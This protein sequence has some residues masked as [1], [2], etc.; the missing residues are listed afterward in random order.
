[1]LKETVRELNNYKVATK[2]KQAA[3]LVSN[4]YAI[5]RLQ[6]VEELQEYIDVSIYG[7][8]GDRRSCPRKRGSP[9][10][11]TLL[12]RHKFYL[13]FENGNCPEYI[14]E[15]YWENAIDNNIVPVVMGGADYKSLAIPNSYID[16][17]DFA[18]PK[19]LAEYLLYL[20][21][22]DT[23][24]REY[25]TWRKLYQHTTPKWACTLC[26]QLHNESLYSPPRMYKNLTRFWDKNQCRNLNLN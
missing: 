3:W 14:T 15:K 24:Y 19:N 23:A 26:K 8:C 25:F 1:M 21:G 13:A 17:Q 18:S 10:C 6:Y 7:H 9:L 11:K 4:C 20:D 5:E 12:K 2:D 16:V 22:N